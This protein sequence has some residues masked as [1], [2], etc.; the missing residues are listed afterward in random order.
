MRKSI[1]I[2]TNVVTKDG[3]NVLAILF[4]V[5]RSHDAFFCITLAPIKDGVGFGRS[6]LDTGAPVVTGV[7]VSPAGNELDLAL[8]SGVT[9]GTGA[10][11][12]VLAVDALEFLFKS[13]EC[14]EMVVI[15]IAC[16]GSEASLAVAADAFVV[17]K[18][19][20]IPVVCRCRN[21]A[22]HA[23]VDVKDEHMHEQQSQGW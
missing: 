8:Q 2:A 1:A 13:G 22:F 23:D 17:A 14:R 3:G 11:H 4:R 9:L 15:I 20:A 12:S 5:R 10:V 21:L 18:Q 6:F 7:A 16:V 19:I